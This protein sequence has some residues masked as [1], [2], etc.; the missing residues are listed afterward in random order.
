MRN[1]QVFTQNQVHSR[2]FGGP[3][4][5][6]ISSLEKTKAAE[7]PDTNFRGWNSVKAFTLIELLVVVL[8]IG[9][10]AAIA[11]PQY[12]KAVKKARAAQWDVIIN[13]ATKAVDMYLLENGL[14]DNSSGKVYLTGKNSVSP[15]AMPGDCSQ[16][17]NCYTNVGGFLAYCKS[18]LCRLAIE[19]VFNADGTTS[20][21][22]TWLSSK[23]TY[24]YLD[25]TSP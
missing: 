18:S 14:P 10:L 7:T 20:P 16:D 23:T 19:F 3:Q 21:K 25:K 2:A 22:N 1:K 12:N 8:I 6:V 13:T 24:L 15:I 9:I 4:G 5:S 11:L 17:N